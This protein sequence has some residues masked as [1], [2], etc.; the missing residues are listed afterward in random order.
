MH[1]GTS[2]DKEEPLPGSLNRLEEGVIRQ[3]RSAQVIP[4]FSQALQQGINESAATRLSIGVL[5]LFVNNA[6][7]SFV[8]Y[9]DLE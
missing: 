8:S 9:S 4:T 5:C 1:K 3:L 7:V 2:S 6:F